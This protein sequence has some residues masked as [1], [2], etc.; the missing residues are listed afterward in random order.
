L[1]K[2]EERSTLLTLGG[3]LLLALLVRLL[4]IGANGFT[5]DIST[6]EA[7]S[8]TLADHPLNEFFA[9]AGFADYPPGYFYVLWFIGHLYKLLVH[10][11]PDYSKLKMFVKLP[12][13]IMDLVDAALIFAIVRRLSTKAWAFGACALFAFN[14]AAIFISA[15][16]GQVD[17]VAA[18]FV[19]GAILLVIEAG[20]RTGTD[21]TYAI[22]GAWV[23]TAASILIKP[24]A[25][26]LVPLLVAFAVATD[27]RPKRLTATALG[28]AAALVFA[29]LATIPFH[30]SFN[31]ID[32]FAWLYGRYLYASGVYPYNS[33]NAFNLY[34]MVHHFWESDTQLLPN[35]TLFG[36]VVGIR[37]Y[38]WGI[39]LFLAAI[40]LVVSRYIGRREPAAFLEG[41]MILS[42][43]YFVL[44]TRMHE[45]YVFDAFLLSI[46]LAALRRRYLWAAI[47]LSL[48]LL[49]NLFYSLDYLHV[50]NDK[51]GGTDPTDLLPWL[52][53][54][55]SLLNVATFFYLGFVYLGAS[56]SDPIERIDL[57]KAWQNLSNPVRQWFSPLAGLTAMTRPDWLIAGGMTLFSFLLA[58]APFT[59][60]M[61]Q[62][63][64]EKIFDEIY[65]ARAGEEYLGHKDIFEYTHPPLTKLII[66]A[67][68]LLFG[69]LH[70]LGDTAVGWRFLNLVV[71]ALM[72]LVIYC[73]AKRLLGSTPFAVMAAGCLLL[74][75]FHY[76]QSRIA[77]P[78]I[79]V[80]FFSLLTLYAFYRFW[81]ASQV[82]VAPQFGFD[83]RN[84][85]RSEWLGV[86]VVT[87]LALGVTA[88][89]GHTWTTAAR[90]VLFLYVDIGGYLAVR[91]L[92]P[93]FRDARPLVS[94][95]EGSR[96]LDGT[97]KTFDGGEAA[98]GNLKAGEATATAKS[99]LAYRDEELQIDYARDGSARYVTPEGEAAFAP[100]GTMTAGGVTIDGASAGRTWLWILSVCAGCLAASKWNGLFDFFVVWFLAA[101]VVSQPYWRPLALLFGR[102]SGAPK[103]AAW[104]NPFGFSLDL[105][106]GTMLFV[107]ATIYA[108]VYIPYFQLGHSFS[109]L[110]GMQKQMYD[111]HSTLTATHPYGSKWW[112]WPLILRPISYYYHDFRTGVALSQGAAC[113]VAEILA[114][115]NP[116]VW[117]M[118]LFSVPWLA[119]VAIRERNKG[120]AVLVTAYFFQWLPW[121]GS[122][123]VAFEYHFLPNL[124]VICLADAVLMQ[125]LWNRAQEGSKHLEEWLG[126][127]DAPQWAERWFAWP[128][129]FV[130]AFGLMVVVAFVFF[131]PLFTGMHI[132]WNAW[133]ARMLH[134]LF[135]NNEWV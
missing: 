32:Q 24:P 70:G 133:D 75:G 109:D 9:K 60:V 90:V 23:L 1:R 132:T 22:V 93:R 91:M 3:L 115:P 105:V 65:Y 128:R 52:S 68:M 131:F 99:G 102:S 81:I 26:V 80:A 127:K 17:S 6:F 86:V 28:A 59:S 118:G 72:V 69:G 47:I 112:Q 33:V 21:A 12:G 51:I 62:H 121:I 55:M 111:Y 14:P 130:W 7:W 135:R 10:S 19:L 50:M 95:A 71:G 41:A 106:V 107:G 83:V 58:L 123:R 88:L 96:L 110:V 20:R 114:L 27:D 13:I 126:W 97:L 82:R 79:T 37:Q 36:H 46:P 122:P 108:L 116:I 104:G 25:I 73:F 78:E 35:T 124:A 74:D 94:Y 98:K 48:T 120:Y 76:V 101:L 129:P 64:N 30:P 16:W 40:A 66:T 11:D 39:V 85:V 45:R 31:P 54:P 77:T 61:F 43:G 8:L 92:G 18:A 4:F 134:W 44:L 29:F 100:A 56:A 119:Y 5:N 125:R 15:Y 63:P 57:S 113:C 117:W 89:V 87:A 42:L 34:A 2:P 103:P 67:S 84:L 38:Y 49:G 53:H